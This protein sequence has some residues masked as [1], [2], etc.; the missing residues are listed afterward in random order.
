MNIWEISHSVGQPASQS[1]SKSSQ[2]P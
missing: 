2:F 1:A